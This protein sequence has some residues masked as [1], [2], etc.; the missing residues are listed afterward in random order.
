MGSIIPAALHGT[1]LE[2]C[3]KPAPARGNSRTR[4]G[5][6][7]RCREKPR[8]TQSVRRAPRPLVSRALHARRWRLHAGQP[9]TPATVRPREHDE[10]KGRYNSLRVVVTFRM[11][12]RPLQ[13]RRS[14]RT[15]CLSGQIVHGRP[16]CG[17]RCQ[18]MTHVL[19]GR[20]REHRRRG[21]RSRHAAYGYCTLGPSSFAAACAGGSNQTNPL[22]AS[23]ARRMRGRKN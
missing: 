23:G 9:R 2:R 4:R 12:P 22:T 18:R 16:T 7:A 19:R 6:R 20:V 8:V 3:P 11:Q 10:T 21:C 14:H 13:R 15:C 1:Y 17:G 5:L